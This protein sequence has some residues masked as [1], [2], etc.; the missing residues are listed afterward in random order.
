MIREIKDQKTI[1]DKVILL[2]KK[3]FYDIFRQ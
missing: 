1:L 2:L 3:V